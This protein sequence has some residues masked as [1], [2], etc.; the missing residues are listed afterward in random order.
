MVG[1]QIGDG[2]QV[3]KHRKCLEITIPIHPFYIPEIQGSIPKMAIFFKPLGRHLFHPTHHFGLWKTI[4]IHFKLVKLWASRGVANFFPDFWSLGGSFSHLRGNL[5]GGSSTLRLAGPVVI[6]SLENTPF[7]WP[8]GSGVPQPDP[9]K[10][11]NHGP[12]SLTTYPSVMGWSSHKLFQPS[13]SPKISIFHVRKTLFLVRN[14]HGFYAGFLLT[15]LGDIFFLRFIF[16]RE[17]VLWVKIRI[18]LFSCFFLS[19]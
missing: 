5:L 19:Y 3:F 2:N 17:A 13:Q 15:R 18:L 1:Y 11:T 9:S 16:A 10:T 6:G 8:F 7:S 4:S 14:P 12:W